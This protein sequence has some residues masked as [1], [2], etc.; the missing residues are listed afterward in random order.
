[1]LYYNV[2][3]LTSPKPIRPSSAFVEKSHDTMVWHTIEDLAADSS[4]S[5]DEEE[6]IDD[7]DLTTPDI[8]LTPKA[9]ASTAEEWHSATSTPC[10]EVPSTPKVSSEGEDWHSARSTPCSRGLEVPYEQ[11]EWSFEV[12]ST[13]MR[14]LRYAECAARGRQVTHE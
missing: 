2:Q 6:N 11:R 1:M 7:T 5:S 9:S 4:S 13:A 3:V 12:S 14:V 8:L 10:P